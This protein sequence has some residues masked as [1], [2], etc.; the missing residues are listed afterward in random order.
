MAAVCTNAKIRK[1]YVQ[2]VFG[3]YIIPCC[4]PAPATNGAN[5]HVDGILRCTVGTL[6]LQRGGTF[7]I[8]V[9]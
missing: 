1:D 7:V 5:L 2:V 9:G 6:C 4:S 8:R 3:L